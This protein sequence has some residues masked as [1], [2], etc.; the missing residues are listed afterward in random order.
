[1]ERLRRRLY[2]DAIAFAVRDIHTALNTRN[3]SPL[4]RFS[5]QTE[6]TFRDMVSVLTDLLIDWETFT[7]GVHV[8]DS[9]LHRLQDQQFGDTKTLAVVDVTRVREGLLWCRELDYLCSKA[10]LFGDEVAPPALRS[11]GL[12][13]RRVRNPNQRRA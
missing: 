10:Y 8:V 7:G 2:L 1:M 12:M 3:R 11:I 4:S 6:A 9:H 13:A 5:W